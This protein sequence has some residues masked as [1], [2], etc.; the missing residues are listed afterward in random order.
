MEISKIGAELLKF[1]WE[2]DVILLCIIFGVI[3]YVDINIYVEFIF[4][5][6]LLAYTGWALYYLVKNKG[7]WVVKS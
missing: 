1:F 3:Q 6:A 4:M 2:I 5:I 7:K